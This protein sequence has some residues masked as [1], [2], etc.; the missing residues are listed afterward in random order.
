MQTQF[1]GQD[2]TSSSF[3]RQVKGHGFLRKLA[4]ITSHCQIELSL[5]T[6]SSKVLKINNT[7]VSVVPSNFA[8]LNENRP[9]WI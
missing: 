2:P 5:L 7:V 6:N 8:L 1:A 9:I 4:Q 3:S